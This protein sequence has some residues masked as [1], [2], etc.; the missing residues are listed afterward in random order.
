MSSLQKHSYGKLLHLN[1]LKVTPEKPIVKVTVTLN[2]VQH[3]WKAGHLFLA[4]R[5]L[6][7]YFSAIQKTGLDLKRK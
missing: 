4:G 3:H 2:K 7:V 6:T 5:L 1:Y